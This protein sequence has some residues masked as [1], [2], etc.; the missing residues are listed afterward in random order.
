MAS[1]KRVAASFRNGKRPGTQLARPQVP[2]LVSPE[3][4]QLIGCMPVEEIRRFLHT[5]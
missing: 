5:H 3:G 4:E 2:L 1:L